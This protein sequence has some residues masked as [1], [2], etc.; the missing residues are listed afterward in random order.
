MTAIEAQ[1]PVNDRDWN[2]CC[3]RFTLRP[4][5]KDDKKQFASALIDTDDYCRPK[6]TKRLKHLRLISII[7]DEKLLNESAK[8]FKEPWL[9]KDFFLPPVLT[10]GNSMLCRCPLEF[11]KWWLKTDQRERTAAV[12]NATNPHQC[13]DIFLRFRFPP[14]ADHLRMRVLAVD[15]TTTTDTQMLGKFCDLRRR[16]PTFLS[17]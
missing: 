7:A 15:P 13:G 4:F 12:C 9:R 11:I 3:R 16:V 6:I 1:F 17:P 8:K 10:T 5:V 2:L 14:N